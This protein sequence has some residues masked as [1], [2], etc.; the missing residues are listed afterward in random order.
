M[1]FM[2]EIQTET[3]L[4]LTR[5][6][7]PFFRTEDDEPFLVTAVDFAVPLKYEVL[8]KLDGKC[9]VALFTC[10]S[11]RAVYFKLCHDLSAVEFQKILKEFVVRKRPPQMMIS[12]NAKTFVATGKWLFTLREDKNLANFLATQAIKWRLNQ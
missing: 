6:M 10:V 8:K 7:L 4:P 9:F 11:T 5:A 2:L 12:D 1:Q 3:A